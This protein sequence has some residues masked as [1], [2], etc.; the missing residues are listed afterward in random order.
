MS[1]CRSEPFKNL[2][3]FEKLLVRGAMD[4]V[5]RAQHHIFGMPVL[6]WNHFG[7]ELF[8]LYLHKLKNGTIINGD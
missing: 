6:I 1:T 3:E 7:A 5:S 8:A 2:A 4:S